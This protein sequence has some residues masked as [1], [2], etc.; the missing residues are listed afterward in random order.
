LL[1]QSARLSG[2]AAPDQCRRLGGWLLTLTT[3]ARRTRRPNRP[4]V[5]GHSR[6][7]P[8]GR[9]VGALRSEGCAD[10]AGGPSGADPGSNGHPACYTPGFVTATKNEP[11]SSGVI[12]A[13]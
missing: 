10:R 1:R 13:G 4:F 2:R 7:A 3:G 12:A 11:N 8:C 5:V 9:V 6:R